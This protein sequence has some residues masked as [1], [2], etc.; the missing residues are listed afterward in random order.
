MS[1]QKL[2]NLDNKNYKYKSDDGTINYENGELSLYFEINNE[3]DRLNTNTVYIKNVEEFID[4]II[5][6]I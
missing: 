4:N 1:Y 5:N 2:K 6:I 3:T